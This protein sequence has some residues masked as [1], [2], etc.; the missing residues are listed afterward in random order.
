MGNPSTAL[1]LISKAMA[2]EQ[3]LKGSEHAQT[4]TAK[5]NLASTHSAIGNKEVALT[6][7]NEVL[8]AERRV[9]GSENSATLVTMGNVAAL[10]TETGN[11]EL[12]LPLYRE[13]LDT[14]R[15]VL[16]S[17]HPDTLLSV[18]NLGATLGNAG[19]HAAAIP[20]IQEA[21]A[22]FTVAYGPEHPDTRHC[23]SKLE[24]NEQCL[25]NPRAAA[26]QQRQQRLDRQ[27]TAAVV[28][29]RILTV[30][31]NPKLSGTTV[32]VLKYKR[33]KDRYMI[34]LRPEL[35]DAAKKSLCSPASLVLAVGTSVIV[36]GLAGAPELNDR[37]GVVEGFDDEKGR[38]AARLEGRKRPAALR[39]QNCLAAA[40]GS[41]AV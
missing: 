41:A 8:E 6:L 14:Q 37:T 20:L 31:S 29:A 18:F 9:L 30:T 34:L 12:A 28:H 40:P 19:D 13:T 3:R 27:Q 2:I 10:H 1:P 21:L 25:T 26:H 22:G 4:L 35:G 15:R 5:G 16:G 23:Q 36:S 32:H 7:F 33:D 24:G 17:H 11:D 39:P 38:Y